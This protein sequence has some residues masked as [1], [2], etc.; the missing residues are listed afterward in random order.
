MK[1][2]LAVVVVVVFGGAFFALP[3][4]AMPWQLAV[5]TWIGVWLIVVGVAVFCWAVAELKDRF[6]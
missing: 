1:T 4:L 3:F 2:A 6:L 5:L